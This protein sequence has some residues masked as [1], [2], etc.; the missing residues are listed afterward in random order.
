VRTSEHGLIEVNGATLRSLVTTVEPRV[1]EILHSARFI[2][3]V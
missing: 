2:P 1:L 3:F